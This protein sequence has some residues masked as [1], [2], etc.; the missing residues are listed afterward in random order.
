[1]IKQQRKYTQKN[2]SNKVFWVNSLVG[3]WLSPV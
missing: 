2:P 3:A 1:M